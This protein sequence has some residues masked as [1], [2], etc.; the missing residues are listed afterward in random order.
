MAI[1]QSAVRV[2]RW[3]GAQHPSV[4]NILRKMQ[5]ESL[6]PYMW[7]NMPNSRYGVRSHGYHKVLYV[8]DGSVELHL[9]DTNERYKL[10]SG[11]RADIP[12]GVRHGTI[13]GTNGAKC[14]EASIVNR[15]TK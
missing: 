7:S 10:R 12:A 13:V 2:T 6:R 1:V 15:A 4:E 14:V 5:Q 9:P 11:D 8:I 3:A